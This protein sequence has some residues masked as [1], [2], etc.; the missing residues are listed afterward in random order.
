MILVSGKLYAM[1]N[2]HH[3][4]MPFS[5]QFYTSMKEF[6]GDIDILLERSQTLTIEDIKQKIGDM[7][8]YSARLMELKY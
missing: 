8:N 6:F 7:T 5:Q 4:F 1:V 2:A 3:P